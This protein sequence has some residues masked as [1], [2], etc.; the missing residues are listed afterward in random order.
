MEGLGVGYDPSKNTI[1]GWTDDQELI[2]L[3]D[4]AATMNSVVEVGSWKGRSAHALLSG[5]LGPVWC[6][7]TFRGSQGKLPDSHKP[8]V[9]NELYQKF[10]SNVGMFP[11]L[12]ALKSTSYDAARTFSDDSIDMVFLDGSHITRDVMTDIVSWLP[13]AR[14]FVCG[15][16]WHM[17]DSDEVMETLGVTIKQ[18]GIGSLW[19]IE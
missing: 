3:H 17:F 11:N 15:H 2:W 12:K 13:K 5:C 7:D 9:Q 4:R 10:L 1:E 14:K 8:K 6:V 16:D 19:I 18:V